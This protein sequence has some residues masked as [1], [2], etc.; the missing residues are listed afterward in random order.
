MLRF[1]TVFS[2]LFISIWIGIQLS[3]EPGYA[4]LSYKEYTLEMPLWLLIILLFISIIILNTILKTISLFRGVILSFPRFLKNRKLN[5]AKKY[6]IL[7]ML[8]LREGKWSKAEK[9]LAKVAHDSTSPMLNYLFAA[10]SAQELGDIDKRDNYIDKA[11]EANEDNIL[12]VQFT[13]ANLYIDNKEYPEA[14][15]IL[16]A[17]L[18]VESTNQYALML[19]LRVHK[20]TSNWQGISNILPSIKKY[21][22]LPKEEILTLELDTY[23]MLLKSSLDSDTDKYEEIYDSMPKQIKVDIDVLAIHIQYLQ[24]ISE[25]SKAEKLILKTLKSTWSE[26]IVL[27]YSNQIMEKPLNN[28]ATIEKFLK[29]NSESHGLYITLARIAKKAKLWNKSKSY[30][31]ESLFINPSASIYAELGDLLNLMGEHDLAAESYKNGLML[32]K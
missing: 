31:E 5:I 4:L 16:T 25:Y 12:A 32:I 29:D 10:R 11:Y 21:K 19:L 3:A 24:K 17:I 15:K 6:T 28:L 23:K 1:I 30:Y 26:N 13:Q 14:E 27:L 9:H 7:G 18:V 22:I 8:E 2:I 20:K